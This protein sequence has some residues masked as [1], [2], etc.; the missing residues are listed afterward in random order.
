VHAFSY[1]G[2]NAHVVLTNY[3]AP[4]PPVV[5]TSPD[6]AYVLP[7]SAKSKRSLRALIARY[8]EHLQ[9]R[10]EQSL[11]D[12]CFSAARR[13]SLPVRI[14]VV[15]RDRAELSNALVNELTLLERSAHDETTATP[16][17]FAFGSA[18]ADPGAVLRQC[19][20]FEPSRS[21][22]RACRAAFLG[23]GLHLPTRPEEAAGTT[24]ARTARALTF[25]LQVALHALYAAQGVQSE[26]VYALGVGELSAAL[27]DGRLTI[28]EAAARV[29][30]DAACWSNALHAS[31]P[32]LR[33]IGFG[34]QRSELLEVVDADCAADVL[35]AE[36]H[37]TLL[38]A[39]AERWR[40]GADV[41]WL[42]IVD[43]GELV[44]LPHYAWDRVPVVQQAFSVRAL[45]TA[46]ELIL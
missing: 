18:F 12:V 32:L 3:D 17:T 24:D 26:H 39:L 14:A 22:L 30:S 8:R 15:A 41:D 9:A 44:E 21:T 46:D 25:S 42:D 38:S 45:S 6:A 40:H 19:A 43:R 7:L 33:V 2:T 29:C 28:E 34:L 37:S 4:P 16:L 5:G 31:P 35:R 1:C 10:T 20:T 13:D 11:R 36:A 23:H 27:L